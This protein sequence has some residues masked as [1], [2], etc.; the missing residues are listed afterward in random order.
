MCAQP[1]EQMTA[2]RSKGSLHFFL[3]FFFCKNVFT[4]FLITFWDVLIKN[5][6]LKKNKLRG[7]K[8]VKMVTFDLSRGLHKMHKEKINL[9][10]KKFKKKNGRVKN[11]LLSS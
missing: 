5:K 11:I 3:L 6:E 7:E 4:H 2:E 10:N 8:M 1:G 9:L